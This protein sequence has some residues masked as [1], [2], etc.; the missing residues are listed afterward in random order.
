[1]ADE[2][3][4]ALGITVDDFYREA[5]SEINQGLDVMAKDVHDYW[6]AV[7][8]RDTGEYDSDLVITVIKDDDGHPA[9]RVTDTAKYAHIVEYGSKYVEAR[10]P[11]AKTARWAGVNGKYMVN[12]P[13]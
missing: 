2:D 8:P 3:L 12:N 7:S 4:D 10:S 5:A 9:R 6:E 13:Q 1:M 11:R